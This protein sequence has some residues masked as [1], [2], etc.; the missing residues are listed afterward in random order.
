MQG[1]QLLFESMIPL[2]QGSTVIALLCDP[3]LS[4]QV[5]LAMLGLH[6]SCVCISWHWWLQQMGSTH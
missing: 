4:I 1:A 5:H 6:P 2:P 3:L